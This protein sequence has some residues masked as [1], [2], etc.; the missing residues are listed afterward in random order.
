MSKPEILNVVVPADEFALLESGQKHFIT[1]RTSR[2]MRER[3]FEDNGQPK[4]FDA[5]EISAGKHLITRQRPRIYQTTMG[6]KNNT[7]PVFVIKLAY[8]PKRSS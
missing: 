7:E 2:T 5:A 3:L 6:P 4:N 8:Q 1:K